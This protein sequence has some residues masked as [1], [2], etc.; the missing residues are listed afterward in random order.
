M[1]L[2]QYLPRAHYVGEHKLRHTF[3][4]AEHSQR[5]TQFIMLNISRGTLHTVGLLSA[6][7][8]EEM[9]HTCTP[10]HLESS[11]FCADTYN[12]KKKK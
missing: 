8:S 11:D 7:Q 5:E 12:L 10:P 4:T 1:K 2:N 9:S 3:H 6:T